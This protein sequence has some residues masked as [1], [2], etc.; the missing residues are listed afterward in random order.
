MCSGLRAALSPFLWSQGPII[1]STNTDKSEFRIDADAGGPLSVKE[2]T[3]ETDA[4]AVL[5][6][7]DPQISLA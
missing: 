1:D 4:G 6:A 5:R 7:F 3:V 2:E